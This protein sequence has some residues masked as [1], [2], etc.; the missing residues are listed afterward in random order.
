MKRETEDGEMIDLSFAL[1]DEMFALG[2]RAAKEGW[3]Q[4]HALRR[5]GP[6]F[7]LGWYAYN[8]PERRASPL[9]FTAKEIREMFRESI[10][11]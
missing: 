11:E 5:N 6:K 10:R 1:S 3:G 9:P 8:P 2:M 4:E 7:Q